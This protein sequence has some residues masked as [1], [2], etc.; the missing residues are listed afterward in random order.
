MT[1]WPNCDQNHQPC[2]FQALDGSATLCSLSECSGDGVFVVSVA[3]LYHY[4]IPNYQKCF[5][6]LIHN[7]FCP[8]DPLLTLG[9]L[10]LEL[11]ILM[12]LIWLSLWA[13]YIIIQCAIGASKHLLIFLLL[14][15]FWLLSDYHYFSLHLPFLLVVCID[16]SATDSIL[17]PFFHTQYCL[18]FCLSLA[19]SVVV[20]STQF[21]LPA[22]PGKSFHSPFTR[23]NT[24][25]MIEYAQQNLLS[26]AFLHT[27]RVSLFFVS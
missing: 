25:V 2:I 8:M 26:I 20:I 9:A 22:N 16:I 15:E 21:R 4:L 3:S 5:L 7:R 10:K 11:L 1:Y 27:T 19:L 23:K 6:S 14:R 18:Q 24:S 12:K 13:Y 17:C